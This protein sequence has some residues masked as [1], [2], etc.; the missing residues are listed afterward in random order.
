ML[1]FWL[2]EL[3]VLFAKEDLQN[4]YD[5]MKFNR[6]IFQGTVYFDETQ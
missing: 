1:I 2:I 6:Q 3:W 4:S 5:K